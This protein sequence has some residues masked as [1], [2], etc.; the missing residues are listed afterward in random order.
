MEYTVPTLSIVFMMV[1]ALAGIAIPVGL[2]L[3]FRKRHGADRMPFW[4]GC[5]IFPVFA[6]GLEQLAYLAMKHWGFWLNVQSNIFAYGAFAGMMAGLFEETGRYFGFAVLLRK[7]R[8]KDINGLMYGAGHGGIEAVI[9]LSV[10]MLINVIFSLQ[11]NA[12]IPSSLGTA[13]AAQSLIAMPS[14]MPLVGA[15]ERLSAVTIHISLSV[16]VWFAVKNKKRFWLFPLAIVLHA[17]VDAV[18]VIM[19]RFVSNIWLIEAAVYLL[20]GVC[21]VL[22][23]IVYKRNSKPAEVA[24]EPAAD[25]A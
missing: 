20:A 24:A 7:K 3:Y 8:G 5:I 9:L 1:A 4:I 17:L 15:V 23:V 10:S 11:S 16:L 6:L 14:W 21:A 2:Y 13:S 19:S 12:G 22:A 25:I 18:A